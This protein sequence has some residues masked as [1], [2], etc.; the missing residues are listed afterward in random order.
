[1]RMRGSLQVFN[2]SA[3]LA[4]TVVA[5]IY[6]MPAYVVPAPGDALYDPTVPSA[7]QGGYVLWTAAFGLQSLVAGASGSSTGVLMIDVK[8]KRKL[9]DSDAVKFVIGN[10]VGGG[11]ISYLFMLRSLL[12]LRA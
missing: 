4:S 7:T 11:T 5:A 9:E 8:S 6:V 12:L 10:V 1:M 2:T 3:V